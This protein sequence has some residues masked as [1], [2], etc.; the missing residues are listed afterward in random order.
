[1]DLGKIMTHTIDL[2]ASIASAR[3]ESLSRSATTYKLKGMKFD[4]SEPQYLITS[5]RKNIFKEP[6]QG[7]NKIQLRA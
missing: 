1:M 5:H 7:T 6:Y 3:P 2:I 4:F